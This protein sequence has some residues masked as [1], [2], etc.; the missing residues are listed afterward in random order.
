MQKFTYDVESI[1]LSDD[2]M[3]KFAH[4]VQGL[5]HLHTQHQV[6]LIL[7]QIKQPIPEFGCDT[8]Q[9]WARRMWKTAIVSRGANE[10]SMD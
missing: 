2:D 3:A 1:T 10:G 7:E 6:C 4:T 8:A 5:C 9:R